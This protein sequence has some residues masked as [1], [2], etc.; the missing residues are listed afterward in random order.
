MTNGALPLL[1]CIGKIIFC[2]HEAA[3]V[4][5]LS[6]VLSLFMRT[7]IRVSFNKLLYG[8]RM[9]LFVSS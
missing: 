7:R 5:H 2:L 8:R 9:Y 6:L 4:A 3:V 1:K